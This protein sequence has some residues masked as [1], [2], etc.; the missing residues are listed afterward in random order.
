MKENTKRAFKKRIADS[1]KERRE[2]RQY[3]QAGKWREAEKDPRRRVAFEARRQ[4]RLVQQG[5]SQAESLQG[6]TN[7]FQPVS[8]LN[9]G[10]TARRAIGKVEVVTDVSSD[11]GTGFLISPDLFLTNQHVVQDT[12]HAKATTVIFDYEANEFGERRPISAFKLDPARFEFYS[13]E[14]KLDFAL[15]ALGQR[16]QGPAMPAE[17]GYCPISDHP[18]RHQIGMN[19]NVIQHPGG[20]LKTIAVRNNLL[21]HRDERRLLYETDTLKGSSGAP[22]F[23]DDWEIVALHHYGAPSEERDEQGQRLPREINEGIR[24]SRIYRFLKDRLSGLPA[25]EQVLLRNALSLFDDERDRLPTV[26][27]PELADNITKPET[28]MTTNKNGQ[29]MTF[30]VPIEMTVRPPTGCYFP[31]GTGVTPQRTDGKGPLLSSAEGKKLDRNYANRNGFDIDFVSGVSIDLAEIVAPL[32]NRVMPLKQ[33]QPN[34]ERG[35]LKYQNFSVIMDSDLR[36]AMITGTN[37]DGETYKT[38]D[39]KTG[40]IKASE[41]ETW[42]ID[43]RIDRDA[44][45]DQDFY[46]AWSHIFDRGHLTRRNDPTWGTKTQAKRANADTFHF[47]NCSPQQWRFNQTVEFW[48]GIERY[49]LE[50]GVFEQVVDT[51][52]TVLQGPLYT[53]EN[54]E[55]VEV[56]ADDVR[57]PTA[58]W[59]L[60]VWHGA[61]GLR[62]VALIASHEELLDEFRESAGSQS[63]IDV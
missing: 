23:N 33:S 46:S 18:D 63:D 41:G 48:Q 49:V 19:V 47:T 51:N 62:A 25:E 40:N 35:E 52:L 58:F 12:N 50:N 15:V 24:I 54:N 36:F 38:V 32:Q 8:F 53:D 17:L 45:L 37:I 6:E 5:M 26:T 1:E 4:R 42:Y 20:I 21:T 7:D 60:V 9:E 3:A 39:R 11:L 59:K 2:V 43:R 56:F 10:A 14:E 29:E 22:V 44:F 61:N 55:Q 30:V 31:A 27:R 13:D 28:P 16:I 57:I 34:R